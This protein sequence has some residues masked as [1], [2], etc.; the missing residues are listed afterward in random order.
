MHRPRTKHCATVCR[1]VRLIVVTTSNSQSMHYKLLCCVAVVTA[2]AR[3]VDE[4]R[5]D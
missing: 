1:C 2:Q 3:P 5:P 4:G